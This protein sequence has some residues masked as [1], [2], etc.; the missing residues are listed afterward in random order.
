MLSEEA[1][2]NGLDG[3]TTSDYPNPLDGVNIVDGGIYF[4]TQTDGPEDVQQSRIT[5]A[6]SRLYT[7]EKFHRH[8]VGLL[9]WVGRKK[10]INSLQIDPGDADFRA[11]SD[12]VYKR[13][14]AGPMGS[15]LEHLGDQALEDIVI[16]FIG[17]EPVLTGTMAELAEKK[18]PVAP[19]ESEKDGQ[20][21]RPANGSLRDDGI[22]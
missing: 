19:A 2:Q 3:K 11:A 16:C 7:D 17:F 18:K 10:K 4:E 12:V 9:S 21:Q 15:L 6:I 20:S 14:M 8:I 1:S 13:L 22:G 5:E